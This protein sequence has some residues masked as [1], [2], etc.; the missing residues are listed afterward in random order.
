MK[1]YMYHTE[2]PCSKIH[3]WFRTGL[4]RPVRNLGMDFFIVVFGLI[5]DA[6]VPDGAV[7]TR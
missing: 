6:G 7:R 1:K 4:I 5:G 2:G 3:T